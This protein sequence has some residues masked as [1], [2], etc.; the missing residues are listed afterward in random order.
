MSIIN[1]EINVKNL[2]IASVTVGVIFLLF[3]LQ[4]I[5]TVFAVSFFIAYLFDP[6]I[7]FFEAR[8]IPRWLSILAL[9]SV[10]ALII[11]LLLLWLIPVVASEAQYLIKNLPAYADNVLDFIH[12]TAD[13]LNIQL[14]VNHLKEL[15][16]SRLT[17]SMH[18][19][20]TGI[21]GI[22][23]SISSAVTTI[24]HLSLI[25]ILVFY[26]LRD[27]DK[28]NEKLFAA[29]NQSSEKDYRRYFT[30]FDRILSEYFRGQII[31]AF[32]LGL[33]YT[34]VLLIVGIK[35][36][37]IVG[38]TAGILSVVPYLG[39]IIGFSTS[40]VLAALQFSDFLHPLMVVIGFTVVQSIEGN[41]LTP[42]IIG[43]S[44][45]LHPTGVIF[46]LLAGG[47]LFGIGGMIMALPAAAF[48]RVV[49]QEKLYK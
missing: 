45:G 17:D 13:R 41:Y 49:I 24:I 7:D 20:F 23:T 39:F 14:D 29:L 34:A 31:V 25:P 19:I 43:K 21:S 30:Q 6:V 22:I 18:G 33:L 15:A 2:I 35:P 44:L 8:K 37:V 26:F 4:S 5:I 12:T 16:G 10:C 28:L 32:L 1:L 11:S 9:M 3:R 46:A 47:S 48:I 36:A 40:I 42:K 27:F 38:L